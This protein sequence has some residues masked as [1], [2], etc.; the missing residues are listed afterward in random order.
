MAPERPKRFAYYVSVSMYLHMYLLCDCTNVNVRRDRKHPMCTTVYVPDVL[1][2]YFH[3]I[4]ASVFA[5][6]CL[7]APVPAGLTTVPRTLQGDVCDV[8]IYGT[9]LSIAR[10]SYAGPYQ[11]PP[12]GSTAVHWSPS[13]SPVTDRL[14]HRVNSFASLKAGDAIRKTN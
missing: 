3:G 5:K 9:S 2:I 11:R 8:I 4:F 10:H 13:S 14:R 1:Y 7:R 6:A 12:I